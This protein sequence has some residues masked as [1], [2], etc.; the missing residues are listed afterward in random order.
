MAALISGL[1]AATRD[2]RRQVQYGI[3]SNQRASFLSKVQAFV[4]QINSILDEPDLSEKD[5]SKNCRAAIQY[6]RCLAEVSPERLPLPGADRF[7]IRAMRLSGVEADLRTDLQRCGTA[8]VHLNQC[9]AVFK[10]LC[11]HAE[12]IE[13]ICLQ[14]N[15][16]PSAT[17]NQ[18]AMSYAM[19]KWLTRPE[20][21]ELYI[22]LSLANFTGIDLK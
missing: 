6:L 9:R 5:L 8:A 19:T 16:I 2:F 22:N 18:S 12:E 13:K 21:F 11:R 20:N 4:A 17:G 3:P 1:L 7:I 15:S 10:R 14:N